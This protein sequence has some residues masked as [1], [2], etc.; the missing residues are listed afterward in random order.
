V[1]KEELMINLQ[2]RIVSMLVIAM[3]STN[4]SS[5]SSFN[6]VGSFLSDKKT[7]NYQRNNSV[8]NLE[9]P[10]DL[11]TPE[12]DK[13][14]VLPG[15][16][17][18]NTVSLRSGGVVSTNR[19]DNFPPDN[20]S[21]VSPVASVQGQRT[22]ALSSIK[23]LSG[24]AVLHIH[25]SY[26][27]ALILTEIMLE[28]LKFSIVSNNAGNGTYHVK[29]NG[30]DLQ[31]EKKKGFLSGTFNYF[32]GLTAGSNNKILSSGKVYQVQLVN[33]NGVPLLSFKSSVGKILPSNAQIIALFN[34]E[35]NR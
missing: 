23:S 29:Y 6:K 26:P 16:S 9:F 12:F 1:F 13:E 14:F 34:D 30:E 25:D 5:C 11:T 2:N 20:T 7:V 27:R 21:S 18:L 17:A 10:P 35:F 28:R 19:V 22:G 3:L 15:A 8:K 32:K 4:L 31:E 33:S 24:K